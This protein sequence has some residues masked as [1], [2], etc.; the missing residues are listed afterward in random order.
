LAH[1]DI[2]FADAETAGRVASLRPAN[3]L[4]VLVASVGDLKAA[5]MVEQGHADAL[6]MSPVS[7]R[8]VEEMLSRMQSAS[9]ISPARGRT[10]RMEPTSSFVG[11]KILAA[12][13]N[14]VNREVLSEALLRLGVKLTLVADG[15]AAVTAAAE[16]AFDLIFM[17]CSMPGMDG[18]EATRMIRA[19][20]EQAGATRV[21]IVALTAHVAG[22]HVYAW[23]DAGMD[24][25]LS[26]PFTLKGLTACLSRW[27]RPAGAPAETGV[28]HTGPV[29]SSM[30]R[31]LER[32]VLDPE[33]LDDVRQMQGPGDDLV[34]RIVSLYSHHAPQALGRLEAALAGGNAPAIAETAHALKSLCR[35]VGAVRLGDRLH[36]IEDRARAGDA[37]T[38]EVLIDE[39]HSEVDA[40]IEALQAV[41][42]GAVADE[43]A[44]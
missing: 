9:G 36:L 21:P 44:A 6:L 27:L 16:N 41:A 2:V 4:L 7:Q 12:D 13:D 20:E 29:Q 22:A 43:E 17:D 24:D 35:N 10:R 25:T 34:G 8:D 40:A 15:D 37:A 19:A 30:A 39:L 28:T 18:Y 31:E 3:V 33:I 14:A 38:P 23:R 5:D 1:G 32:P 26:K 11:A 42:G